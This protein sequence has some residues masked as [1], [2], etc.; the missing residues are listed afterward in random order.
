MASGT[1]IVFRF[2]TTSGEKNFSYNYADDDATSANVKAAMQAMITNGSIFRYPP[3]TA[4]S[5]KYVITT[6]GEYDIS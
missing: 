1:K 5:A 2:G 3:L 6:E 4:I